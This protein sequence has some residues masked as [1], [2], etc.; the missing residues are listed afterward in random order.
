MYII[1][2]LCN[3]QIVEE[4]IFLLCQ[5]LNIYIVDLVSFFYVI[6]IFRFIDF[7]RI[8]FVRNKQ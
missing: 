7:E 6:Q 1:I 8:R 5:A 3:I 4:H 2:I